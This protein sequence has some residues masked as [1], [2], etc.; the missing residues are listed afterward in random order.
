MT[1]YILV[2]CSAYEISPGTK[3]LWRETKVSATE[4][5]EQAEEIILQQWQPE[6]ADLS[7]D[8]NSKTQNLEP[9]ACLAWGRPMKL[10]F[11]IG[12]TR[13]S[14]R[15]TLVLRN[16]QAEDDRRTSLKFPVMPEC[17]LWAR[18]TGETQLPSFSPGQPRLEVFSKDSRKIYLLKCLLR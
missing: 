6:G 17:G 18:E 5:V 13:G 12:H 11:R 4:A 8:C 1:K 2:T 9:K 10:W 7:T 14:S 3:A 16:R 15:A